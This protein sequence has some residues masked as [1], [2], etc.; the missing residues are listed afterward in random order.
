[1][2]PVSRYL[3]NFASC[4]DISGQKSRNPLAVSVLGRRTIQ[5]VSFCCSPSVRWIFAPYFW[6]I[7]GGTV[8]IK[9]PLDSNVNMY[10][11]TLL[12]V[13]IIIL[14]FRIF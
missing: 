1:M 4:W 10:G 11:S 7:C 3:E 6:Y 2:G 9:H 14:Y 13:H 5:I 8:L 12:F